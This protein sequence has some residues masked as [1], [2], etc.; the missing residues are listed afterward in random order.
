M[1]RARSSRAEVGLLETNTP[2]AVLLSALTTIGSFASLTTS[3]HRG[4]ASM[5]ELLGIS[6]M[7]TLICT[8]VVLPMLIRWF[9][10]RTV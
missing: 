9:T 1:I 2:R 10:G 7:F 3:S 5:G 6:I 8:L 4:L